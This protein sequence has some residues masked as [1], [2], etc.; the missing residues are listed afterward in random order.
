MNLRL[1]TGI[2]RLFSS[3]N[4][5]KHG[6]KEYKRCDVHTN[7]VEGYCSILKHRMERIIMWTA[8]IY[9]DTSSVA[10]GTMREKGNNADG[11]DGH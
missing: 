8:I 7:T 4:I 6:K 2:V 5:V 3:H 1:I 10:S 11:S 9:A